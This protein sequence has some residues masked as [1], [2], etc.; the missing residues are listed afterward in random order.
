[1]GH[2]G[3]VMSTSEKKSNKIQKIKAAKLLEQHYLCGRPGCRERIGLDSQLAHR[4]PQRKWCISR[5]G[6]EVI[7]HPDNMVLVCSLACNAAVQ[8]N[9]ISLEAKALAAEIRKKITEKGE[10]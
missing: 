7:H 4:I 9:P 2:E 8:L 5:W 10:K 3:D 6:L 1:M